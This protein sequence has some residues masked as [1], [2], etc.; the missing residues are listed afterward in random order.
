MAENCKG[1]AKTESLEYM[2]RIQ[3][4]SLRMGSLI[5][6]M[7]DLSR[8]VRSE[9]KVGQ[10]DLS[11]MARSIIDD[12]AASE[13][14]RRVEVEV[15]GDLAAEGDATLLQNVLENLLGNAWKFT[16]RGES[17]RIEFGAI[18]ACPAAGPPQGGAANDLERSEPSSPPSPG[19]GAGGRCFFVRDN[20]AGFDMKYAG[21]LFGAFQRLHGPQEFEGNGIG[22]AMVRR[23]VALHGGRVW[24]EGAPELGATFYFT[25]CSQMPQGASDHA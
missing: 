13:P 3:R 5:D 14:A 8:V 9:I 11:A 15:Q 18:E 25:L 20:G 12:L 16:A 19:R 22:L 23:I 6:D 21:K 7:L 1:C 2:A 10:V 4:A 24:A 17:A